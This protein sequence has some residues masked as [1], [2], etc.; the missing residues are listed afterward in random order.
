MSAA[1]ERADDTRPATGASSGPGRA[2]RDAARWR[3]ALFVWA[4]GC[5]ACYLGW[6]L[7]WFL[8]DDAFISFRYA[9]NLVLGHGLVF[10]AGERVEGYTNFLWTLTLA[11]AIALGLEPAGVAQALGIACYAGGV[12]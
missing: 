8:C 6:R 1:S 5:A 4:A 2:A 9:E 11:A 12:L 10:N 7:Y 3:S